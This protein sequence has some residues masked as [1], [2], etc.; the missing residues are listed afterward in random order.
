MFHFLYFAILGEPI[1][2]LTLRNLNFLLKAF[3]LG[4]YLD[5][6]LIPTFYCFIKRIFKSWYSFFEL[7]KLYLVLVFDMNCLF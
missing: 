4:G 3:P 1:L 2:I 5:H 7:I 6:Y